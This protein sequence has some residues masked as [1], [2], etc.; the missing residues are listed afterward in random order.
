MG[1][2]IAVGMVLK[3]NEFKLNR[4]FALGW[5]LSVIF[6]ENRYPLFGIMLLQPP[7]LHLDFRARRR[8]G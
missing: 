3:R 4:H 2:A 7:A 1:Y 5:C 8:R 6:S